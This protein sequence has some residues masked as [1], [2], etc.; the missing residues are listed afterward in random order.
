MNKPLEKCGIKKLFHTLINGSTAHFSFTL[1]D[2]DFT[3]S[4]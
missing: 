1:A 2:A 4:V 3:N